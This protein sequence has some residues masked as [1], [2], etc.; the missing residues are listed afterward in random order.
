MTVWSIAPVTPAPALPT[1]AGVAQAAAADLQSTLTTGLTNIAEADLA[2]ATALDGIRMDLRSAYGSFEEKRPVVPEQAIAN[3]SAS[4]PTPAAGAGSIDATF[5]AAPL[6]TN[7]PVPASMTPGSQAAAATAAAAAAAAAVAAAGAAATAATT[8]APTAPAAPPALTPVPASSASAS[9]APLTAAN[10]T[11]APP[12]ENWLWGSGA[13]EEE[14]TPYPLPMSSVV[15]SVP[16][17]T[18]LI[19]AGREKKSRAI[20]TDVPGPVEFVP[21]E[22]LDLPPPRGFAREGPETHR[23]RAPLPDAADAPEFIDVEPLME[24]VPRGARRG[25]SE[26]RSSL[27]RRS[28]ESLRRALSID[29]SIADPPMFDS[30]QYQGSGQALNLP[31]PRFLGRA[32]GFERQQ[33][34]RN[35]W[36]PPG[37]DEWL[38]SSNAQAMKQVAASEMNSG[39]ESPRTL[40]DE[41]VASA[42]G[43][44]GF[45]S[46]FASATALQP[47]L[48]QAQAALLPASPSVVDAGSFVNAFPPASAPS[49]F[50]PA[51]PPFPAAFPLPALRALPPVAA[52]A[53]AVQS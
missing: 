18:S 30:V 9:A 28:D 14:S 7:P 22:V 8:S 5:S 43:T 17:P 19:M 48:P 15:T 1:S 35:D 29:D 13:L 40:E 44:P 45:G 4:L 21:V 53:R 33:P 37:F 10:T 34:Q 49:A 25:E 2:V 3:V 12:Y 27:E 16:L 46:P 6:P 51:F 26:Y 23:A 41:E 24:F 20:R 31:Q 52:W 50:P 32:D 39:S 36:A 38:A 11:S 47:A 42:H